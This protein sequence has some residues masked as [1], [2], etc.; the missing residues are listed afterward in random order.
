[1]INEIDVNL[2]CASIDEGIWSDVYASNSNNRPG[3]N[4]HGDR[5]WRTISNPEHLIK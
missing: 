3:E 2:V 5:Q 4:R 1:M